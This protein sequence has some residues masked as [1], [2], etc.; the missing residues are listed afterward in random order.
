MIFVL[1]CSELISF[2]LFLLLCG[3]YVYTMLVNKVDQYAVQ[4]HSRSLIL[5]PIGRSYATSY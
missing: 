5:M 3:L 2:S 4:G 1:L